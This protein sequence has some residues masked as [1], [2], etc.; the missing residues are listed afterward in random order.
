MLF[1][2][3]PSRQVFDLI[4]E[5]AAACVGVEC[6]WHRRPNCCGFACCGHQNIKPVVLR[7]G[8]SVAG[9]DEV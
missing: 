5:I 9:L 8:E 7:V 1:R 4:E 6:R 3:Q 2:Q